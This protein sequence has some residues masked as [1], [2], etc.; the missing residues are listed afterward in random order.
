MQIQSDESDAENLRPIVPS[1][2]TLVFVNEVNRLAQGV[3]R[4]A[5]ISFPTGGAYRLA[6]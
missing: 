5:E 3:P 6:V 1:I 4:R 2:L